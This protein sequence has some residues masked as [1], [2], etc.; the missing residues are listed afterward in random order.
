MNQ[1]HDIINNYIEKNLKDEIVEGLNQYQNSDRVRYENDR[2]E[3]KAKLK[4]LD[5]NPDTDSKVKELIKLI[6]Q[7]RSS[8]D[9]E[10]EIYSDLVNF[11][12][13]YYDSGDFISQRRY[14][15]GIYAIPYSG[16]E[17]KLYW[18]NHDQYYIKSTDY[19]N[20]YAFKTPVG[21]VYFRIKQSE[22]EQ[23]NN[24]AEKDKKR[25][26]TVYTEMPVEIIDNELYFYFFYKNMKDDKEKQENTNKENAKTLLHNG[27][28]SKWLLY[29]SEVM[30]TEKNKDRTKLEMEINNFTAKIL[31]TFL[32]IKTWVAFL[33]ASLTFILK[34][35]SCILMIW[36]LTRKAKLLTIYQ[37]LK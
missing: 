28:L 3:R 19:L 17:M 23:N 18:A 8:E 24:K 26:I 9:I 6:S 16:E 29:L 25:K 7:I 11:F 13:R 34:M 12:S 31:L 1:K 35:K 15:D 37:K 30:P 14:K 20:S 5:L 2:K 10:N 4:E 22:E 36:V 27:K 21:K 33:N 32:F